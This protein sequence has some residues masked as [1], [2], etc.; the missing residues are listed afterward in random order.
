MAR[1]AALIAVIVAPTAIFAAPA[2]DAHLKKLDFKIQDA[3]DALNLDGGVDQLCQCN[4]MAD[5]H[6]PEVTSGFVTPSSC[7]EYSYCRN[8]S[9]PLVRMRA[10]AC[11]HGKM[12]WCS[13]D[14]PVCMFQSEVDMWRTESGSDVKS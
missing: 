2:L 3:I 6:C 14:G 4:S 5:F 1:L 8:K 13:K 11:E 9:H 7:T 12:V 10:N